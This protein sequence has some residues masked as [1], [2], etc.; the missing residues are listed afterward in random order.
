MQNLQLG[1]QRIVSGL[2]VEVAVEQQR[3]IARAPRVRIADAPNRHA[4]TFWFLNTALDS[5]DVVSGASLGDVELSDGDLL[6]TAGSKRLDGSWNVG[7]TAD[8]KMSLRT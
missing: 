6:D 2:C 5:V 3:V 1:H 8:T 7:T 4:H